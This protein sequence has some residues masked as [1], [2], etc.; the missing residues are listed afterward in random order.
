MD[1]FKIVLFENEYQNS[2]PKYREL[3]PNEGKKCTGLFILKCR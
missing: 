1:E 3:T 2:F